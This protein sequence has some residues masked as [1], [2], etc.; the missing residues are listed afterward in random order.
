MNTL[1]D[2]VN[3]K[4]THADK[5]AEAE[6]YPL[7]ME[8][9]KKYKKMK[10]LMLYGNTVQDGT[11]TPDTPVDVVSV[12]EPTVNLATAYEVC[13]GFDYYTEVIEDGRN[14]VRYLDANTTKANPFGFKENTQYTVSFDCKLEK[15]QWGNDETTPTSIM[16]VFHYTDGTMGAVSTK[17]G[18]AMSV[19]GVWQ[20]KTMT[21]Q[22]GKTVLGI[23]TRS[24][25]YQ[26]YNYIDV[27]T[28]QV[29]EGTATPYEPYGKYKISV[30]QKGVNLLKDAREIY[31]GNGAEDS[32]I[33]NM[34]EEVIEDGRECIRFTTSN[35]TRYRKIKFKENTQYTFSFDSK[36]VKRSEDVTGYDVCLAIFY[37]DGSTSSVTSNDYGKFD[38][39]IHR[40]F[41]S[42][43]NK[44]IDYIGLYVREY[45]I[46]CYIDINTFQIQEG[47][48]ATPYE[49]YVEPVATNIFLNEPL[50]K[51]GNYADY[52]DFKNDKVV[53][54]IDKQLVDTS[55]PQ[56]H[57][58]VN[59]DTEDVLSIYRG[60]GFIGN[61]YLGNHQIFSSFFPYYHWNN[62]GNKVNVVWCF[63]VSAGFKIN[64][65]LIDDYDY[66]WTKQQKI[67]AF[68]KWAE[69]IGL[70]WYLARKTPREEPL[71]I[72]LPKLTAK[73]TIIEVDTSLVPSNTYG[74]YIK[75]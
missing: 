52:I 18:I 58:N 11:P 71:N 49:L 26:N 8:N 25:Q 72:N 40:K 66:S 20:S 34:Y 39:W 7:K 6:G 22:A 50:R 31:N 5:V 55:I 54:N 42:L 17:D 45:R 28:F 14:C 56:S 62:A 37:T 33:A 53:R 35:S 44:T 10:Q 36:G 32:N 75:K 1:K 21:S 60:E 13:K 9:C 41:I 46:Y 48:T 12:G 3:F 30:V 4:L 51:L 16:M 47:T 64:T 27:N 73:T 68:L 69:S 24:Y 59:I 70:D 61:T 43:K 67:T 57:C 63:G 15:G 19:R 23:G 74:K 65:D 38:T 2:Y 29:Q